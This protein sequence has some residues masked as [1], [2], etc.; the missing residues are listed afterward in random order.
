[1]KLNRRHALGLFGLSALSATAHG[2]QAETTTE[3]T[4]QH[5]VASGDPLQDR[6]ILW[7]RVTPDRV[8]DFSIP[9]SWEIATDADFRRVIRRG[10]FTTS[11]LRDFTVK[12]DVSGL[13]PAKG[14]VYR[15]TCG[16]AVSPVGRTRTLPQGAVSNMV[17]AVTSCSLYMG[18]Y[19]NAYKD[20]AEQERVDLVLHLGDYIYEYG[21]T[22]D[23]L[24]STVGLRLGR[25]VTPAHESVSLADYRERH[26]CYK[27][28]PELQAA[29]ARA[30]W[31]V[32]WDDHD[33]ANDSWLAG[34]QN[35]SPDTEGEWPVRRDAAIRAFYEWLPIR[36]PEP[37]K[38][39]I[40]SNRVFELGDLAT[41]I[42]VE[43]R[44]IGRDRQV[45]LRNPDDV[46]WNVLDI[47]HPEQPV[48]VSDPEIYRRMMGLFRSGQ[49]LPPPYDVRIDADSLRR[50]VRRPERSILG[51]AQEAW[52]KSQLS[53]SVAQGKPWQ[54]LGNQMILGR[55]VGSDIHAF[56]G[57]ERWAHAKSVISPIL[58]PWMTQIE[59]LPLDLPF[60]FDGWNAYPAAR[61]RMDKILAETG[62]R[63]LILAGDSHAFWVNELN[64]ADNR[65]LAAEF[66]VTSI[67]S[68][69]LGNM[70]GNVEL[71]PL[72][73]QNC[74]EVKF[75]RHLT[76][77]YGL[78]TLSA[79][80][81][82]LDLIGISTTLSRDYERFV[83]KSFR[84][85]PNPEGGVQPVMEI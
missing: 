66:G 69:S 30:P 4:F 41:L 53:A 49:P 85:R 72:Y 24:G 29:H 78:V 37:G 71:G 6:V 3:A 60:E 32:V 38:P 80:E 46:R 9:V 64:D 23:Q 21:S 33:V 28:E 82:R 16:A 79:D 84:V 68:S 39:L 10:T 77:G 61:D 56:M 14:Y 52:L 2:V 8:G 48:V 47:S 76:R 20:L 15:F 83:L 35:H 81:A 74:P 18:G 67:T 73:D 31:I 12:V 44:L 17:I 22:P 40:E 70:L 55:T 50:A 59:T 1:M 13:D 34:A 65:R 26:A 36:D 54:V 27:L 5:G 19:F 25:Q 7:T 43:N 51:D 62:S 75:C 42:M 45:D 57:P 63:T 11:A 58:R